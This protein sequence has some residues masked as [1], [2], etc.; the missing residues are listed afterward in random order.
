VNMTRVSAVRLCP[1]FEVLE[2]VAAARS[3]HGGGLDMSIFFFSFPV[4]VRL[5]QL[6][7]SDQQIGHRKL[8]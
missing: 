1:S 5:L 6:S 4:H 7:W 2:A 8:P 3:S